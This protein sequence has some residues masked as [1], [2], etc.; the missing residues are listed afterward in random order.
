MGLQGF[1]KRFCDLRDYIL[2]IT[3]EIWEGRGIDLIRH[4]Y[5]EDCPVKTPAGAFRGVEK[6]V[7]STLATLQEFPDRTLLG[8]DVIEGGPVSGCYYSSHRIL[9]QMTHMG[10]GQFGSPTWRSAEVM[11]IADCLCQNNRIVDEWLVRDQSGLAL[12]LGAS[13]VTLGQALAATAD[14]P[15]AEA[16]VERWRG[17]EGDLDIDSLGEVA[18]RYRDLWQD[19]CLDRLRQGYS[20]AIDAKVPGGRHL[21]GLT[22]LESFWFEMKAAFP[23]GCYR[24]HHYLDREEP[25]MPRRVALRWSLHTRHLGAGRFGQPSGADVVLLGITHAE[26]VR[27]QV[28]RE[29]HLL[30]E[31]AIHAQIAHQQR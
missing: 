5:S 24:I 7:Q 16:L 17:A 1:D 11:T 10:E 12:Q 28:L 8:E 18:Q 4:Y 25:G 13:P 27:G 22:Q 19:A 29:W 23:A 21:R 9:S 20:R 30:D 6:V 26:I 2:T 3:E 14:W 15:D 31:I